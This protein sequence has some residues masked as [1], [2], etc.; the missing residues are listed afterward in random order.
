M[1]RL[2]ARQVIKSQSYVL[3]WCR[4]RCPGNTLLHF[5]PGRHAIACRVCSVILDV[6]RSGL[7]RSSGECTG[8]VLIAEMTIRQ[9]CLSEACLSLV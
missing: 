5:S 9:A 4:S 6:S 8:G 2:Q 3:D 1:F 7:P